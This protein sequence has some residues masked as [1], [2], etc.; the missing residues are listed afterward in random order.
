MVNHIF[1]IWGGC[2]R[3]LI[4]YKWNVF[5]RIIRI[6]QSLCA[7]FNKGFTSPYLLSHI[8]R[9]FRRHFHVYPENEVQV[10]GGRALGD[11]IV[12]SNMFPMF[13]AGKKHPL[14]RWYTYEYS[15]GRLGRKLVRGA[16]LHLDFCFLFIRLRGSDYYR[17][18]VGFLSL[19]SVYYELYSIEYRYLYETRVRRGHE[20]F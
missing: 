12:T 9:E 5:V 3:S 18:L 20:F 4:E 8:S 15:F 11:R 17:Y 14:T 19:P 10:C 13:G 6:E 7:F 2:V 16:I 1:V